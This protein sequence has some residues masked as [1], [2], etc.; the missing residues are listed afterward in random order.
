[1]TFDQKVAPDDFTASGV[2]WERLGSPIAF[3]GGDLLVELNDSANGYVIADAVRVERVLPLMIAEE[4]AEIVSASSTP[5]SVEDIE[6]LLPA[7]AAQWSASPASLAQVLNGVQVVVADLPPGILG[8]ASES[9]G[10]VWLDD[11]AAGYG[12]NVA[13]SQDG[14]AESRGRS[15]ES[16]DPG[17]R[18]KNQDR[19]TEHYDLLTVLAHELGHLLGRDHEPD[20]LMSSHL[21]RGTRHLNDFGSQ[22]ELWDVLARSHPRAADHESLDQ[23][24]AQLGSQGNGVRDAL[25]G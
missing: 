22:D 7:A 8:L 17:L 23:V 1:M 10:V 9:T 3:A 16:Q 20:G 5:L 13:E 2:S 25:P 19:S 21:S 4:G 6:R 18:S 15:A 12:W 11:D 14:I 24:F